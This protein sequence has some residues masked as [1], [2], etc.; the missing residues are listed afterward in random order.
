MRVAY[1]TSGEPAAAIAERYGISRTTL[2][3]HAVNEGWQL[4]APL[5]QDGTADNNDVARRLYEFIDRK[6]AQ[7]EARMDND[8]ALSVAEHEAETR[9]LGQL[10]RGFEKVTNLVDESRADGDDHQRTAGVRDEFDDP[11]R[12]REELAQRIR[13]LCRERPGDDTRPC[14]TA[15]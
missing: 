4:R 13:R 14:R 3:L 7:L 9:A 1:E 6:L 15:G 5:S 10:I 8:E 11:K 12:L 2:E